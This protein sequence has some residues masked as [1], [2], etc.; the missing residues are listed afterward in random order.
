MRNTVIDLKQK[1]TIN[2]YEVYRE[3][4]LESG[5]Q[6]GW[7]TKNVQIDKN[8][9]VGKAN[10]IVMPNNKTKLSLQ[11]TIIDGTGIVIDV[12]SGLVLLKNCAVRPYAKLSIESREKVIISDSVFGSGSFF[13]LEGVF[14]LGF[15][16]ASINNLILGNSAKLGLS[17]KI[18]DIEPDLAPV[19][20]LSDVNMLNLGSL[21]ITSCKGDILVN[22]V[23]VGEDC[24]VRLDNYS[25]VLIDELECR[26]YGRFELNNM[27]HPKISKFGNEIMIVDMDISQNSTVDLYSAGGVILDNQVVEHAK[28]VDSEVIVNGNFK[29]KNQFIE[30]WDKRL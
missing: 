22:K 16:S 12:R 2:N 11:N 15:V 8:S 25:G 23:L 3:V 18:K 19:V 28:L 24:T 26:D 30:E 27:H 20:S 10:A 4:D 14:N 1:K 21:Y 17:N 13:K 29:S 7:V 9:W 6:G 5:E